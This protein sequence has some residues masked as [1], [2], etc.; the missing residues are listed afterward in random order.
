MLQKNNNKA[1]HINMAKQQL[2]AA[3]GKEF[4]INEGETTAKAFSVRGCI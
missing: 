1:G 2:P 3:A 4:E